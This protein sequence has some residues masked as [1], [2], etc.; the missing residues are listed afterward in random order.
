MAN[1]STG[2][3]KKNTVFPK[4]VTVP[5]RRQNSKTGEYAPNRCRSQL[6]WAPTGQIRNNRGIK[7]NNVSDL[8]ITQVNYN[9]YH[10]YN[11]SCKIFKDT[12]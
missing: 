10:L 1:S 5:E 9:I 3:G 12:I 2:A 6:E 7:I 4:Y 11:L 8:S